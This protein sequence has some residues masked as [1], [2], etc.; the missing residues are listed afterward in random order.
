M[1]FTP[2][3]KV[4]GP[5]LLAAAT[6][7][8]TLAPATTSAQR[9]K[10]SPIYLVAYQSFH[11]TGFTRNFNPWNVNRMD[12]TTGA[13]YEPLMIIT[14]ASGGHSYPWLATG[15][16]YSN[17]GKT[18]SVTLRPNLKWSD[19]TP[20]T[21]ADVAFTFNYG[22]TNSFADQNGLW[23]GKYLQSVTAPNPTTVVFKLTT[24]DT[25]LLPN[26]LTNVQIVPQHIWA[27][28]KNA[29]TF[30]NPNPVGSGPF[31]QVTNFSSQEFIL[32]KNPHYWQKL[33]YDGIKVPLFLDNQGADT[34][35][36]K[37]QLD[38]TGN[39]V[40][41]I[42][43]VYVGKDPAHF[44]Y[45]FAQT[46]PIGLW[47][48]DQKYPYSMVGFRKA[49]SNAIDRQRL[50]NFGENGYELAA[51]A[52]GLKYIF[53]TWYDKSLDAQSTEMSAYNPA[54][55]KQELLSLGFT[56]KGGLLYDPH[57][58]K[59]S[60]TMVVPTGWSDWVLDLQILTQDFKKIGIDASYKTL[61][62]ATWTT[63]ANEG[64][65]DAQLHWTGFGVSP[66]YIYYSY[67]SQQSFTPTGTDATLNGQ[68]N[69]ARY[70]SPQA[71]SLLAQFRTTTDAQT[72]HKIIAQVEKIQ[73]QDFPM[74]PI[75]TSADWYEYSTLHFTG[76]PT[77]QNFYVQ[78]SL[79]SVYTRVYVLTHLKPAM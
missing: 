45:Y 56:Y 19:G 68:N 70:V 65:L 40:A 54:K 43:H 17:G 64:L 71:T 2:R 23:A 60:F 77:Q 36:A 48:N 4:L 30:A 28:V 61:D 59:V 16:K 53:P 18:L 76:W 31:T 21:A 35:R 7:A 50:S 20:L 51:D 42:Q 74:I 11:P 72:Q 12:F 14:W 6:I 66:Y 10:A 46:N 15:Y 29:A 39:F 49:L 3:V 37:G 69:F 1:K 62:P 73:L 24:F 52:T 79:N 58:H 34:A 22:K 47:F 78:A 44:H 57:G 55:A 9:A 26:I 32:A 41:D 67:M 33:S 38:W 8:L 63:K 5:C 27:S 13:I 75:L 25:T